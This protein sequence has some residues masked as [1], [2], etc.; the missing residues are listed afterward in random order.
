MNMKPLKYIKK[1]LIPLLLFTLLLSGCENSEQKIA[2]AEMFELDGG[3][4][5]EGVSVGDGSAEFIKAYRDYVIWAAYTNSSSNYMVMSI[6]EIPYEDSISTLIANFFID[7]VPT[8]EEAICE[9]NGIEESALYSLLS[10]SA[11]LRA[12]EVIYRYLRFTWEDSVI[13][14]IDSGELNYNETYE[15]PPDE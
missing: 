12:H 15:V 2:S 3:T 1:T 7:D 6:N 5:S 10:S 4:T 13:T 9:D 11:Y 8:S 14:D